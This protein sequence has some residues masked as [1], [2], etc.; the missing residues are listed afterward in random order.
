M[1]NFDSKLS[2]FSYTKKKINWH[3]KI[4]F[5]IQH[6]KISN[7]KRAKANST[8]HT[9]AN[10]NW[11]LKLIVTIITFKSTLIYYCMCKYAIRVLILIHCRIIID[12][13]RYSKNTRKK[14]ICSDQTSNSLNI[15][16]VHHEIVTWMRLVFVPWGH[17]HRLKTNSTKKKKNGNISKM[18]LFVAMHNTKTSHVWINRNVSVTWN[19]WKKKPVL[20]IVFVWL[21]KFSKS[22]CIAVKPFNKFK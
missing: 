2:N 7:V 10:Y 14:K 6:T 20:S 13:R 21:I 16:V 5:S 18:I 12:L 19:I 3:T 4:N 1:S 17:L 8:H 9:T 15:Q 22:N 11:I